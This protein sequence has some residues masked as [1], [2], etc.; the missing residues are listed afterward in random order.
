MNDKIIAFLRENPEGTDSK[1]IAEE[2]L[3]FKAPDERLAHTMVQA[4]LGRDKRA[5]YG[6]DRL[7]RATKPVAGAQD[8]RLRDMPWAAVSVMADKR[9]LVHVSVW[10]VLP[11]PSCEFSVWLSDPSEL[12]LEERETLPS[13]L[14]TPYAHLAYDETLARIADGLRERTPLFVCS[15]DESLLAW[16]CT[17]VGASLNDSGML[18]T[19]LA[20]A[21]GVSI[22]KPLGLTNLAVALTGRSPVVLSAAGRG[23]LLAECALE[24]ISRLEQTGLETRAAIDEFFSKDIV[25]FDFTGKRFNAE[26]LASLSTGPGVYGFTDQNGAYVYIGKAANVRRR[27]S[28]YFGRTDESPAKLEQLRA[29]AI[30]LTV[31][32]CG[33]ELESLIYEHRLIRKYSPRLNTQ[34][35]IAERKGQY[36]PIDDCVVLLPHA[37][38]DKGMS[39]WFRRGQKIQLRPFAADF[40]DT[41]PLEQELE[42]FFFSPRLDAT[43][44][45]FPEQEIAQRWLSRKLD[46]LPVVAVSRMASGNEVLQ[47]MRFTWEEA[48]SGSLKAGLTV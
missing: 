43:P 42:Q 47:A 32:L 9:R 35:E 28:G 15:A 13:A 21:A 16:R 33:S 45:D 24:L 7:W 1:R 29:E 48:N 10:S 8:T 38:E 6:T 19:Q 17:G 3:K 2:F 14:D 18:A 31:H 44:T 5:E 23:K 11:E 26:Q 22:T 39:I 12:S 30:D 36:R 4:V 37:Q 27:V 46:S 40:A 41:G 34:V 20:R 25:S